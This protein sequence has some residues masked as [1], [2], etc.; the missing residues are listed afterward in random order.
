M[1]LQTSLSPVTIYCSHVL[2]NH[3]EALLS[4]QLFADKIP[5]A[6]RFC[7]LSTGENGSGCRVP[8]FTELFQ[9]SCARVEIHTP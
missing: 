3:E 2:W 6:E 5:K 4:F 9:D 8:L 1:A 7:G